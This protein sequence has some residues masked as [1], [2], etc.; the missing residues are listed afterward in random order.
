LSQA[1]SNETVADWLLTISGWAS[2]KAMNYLRVVRLNKDEP[3]G[4]EPAEFVKLNKM[5]KYVLEV[6]ELSFLNEISLN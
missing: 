5:S 3:W 1:E 4:A 6:S 2:P